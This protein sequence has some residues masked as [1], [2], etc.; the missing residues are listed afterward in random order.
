MRNASVKNFEMVIPFLEGLKKTNPG[1]VIGYTRDEEKRLVDLHV[2]PGIMNGLLKFVRPVVSLDATHLRSE[3][4]GTLYIASVLSGCNDIFPIGFMISAGNEDG[5]TWKKMLELLKKACP[6]IDDQGYGDTDTDGVVRPPFLFISDRDKGLKEALKSVFPNKYEM[7]CARHIE[8]NVTQKYGKQC[9]KFVCSIAKSFSTRN[10]SLLLDEIRK[11]KPEAATYLEGI[12][13]SGVLWQSTQ[14]YSDSPSP[15]PAQL[16]PRYGIVT[17]NTSESANSMLS[18]ARNLG[19]LEAVNKILD[20]MTTR[21]CACRKKYAERDGS[22]VV[23]RV[24]QILKRRWDAAASMTVDELEVG[25]GDFK[26]VEPISIVDENGDDNVQRMARSYGDPD[27]VLVVKPYLEWCS[28]GVW[29]DFLYPC[30]H[31]CA[32]FRK[33]QEKEF[34]YVLRSLVHPFYTFEFVHNTFKKNVFPVCLETTVYDGETKEPNVP[35]RQSGRPKTKRIRKRSKFIESE[36]SPVKCSICGRRGHNRRTCPSA[37]V[38]NND[39]K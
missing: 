39:N 33:W 13:A 35:K 7:S 26:V 9:S 30:R 19:W 10:A 32:V 25:C 15:S 18:E 17:S 23:P 14:W 28:C 21:V 8:A 6:I 24:A 31:A 29:Q 2:F 22:E 27:R 4:K 36:D 20:I 37:L 11:V 3:H 5:A 1:S 38:G 16:P 34:S 12:T